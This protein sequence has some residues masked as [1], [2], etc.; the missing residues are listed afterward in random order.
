MPIWIGLLKSSVAL[1]S[2]IG[3]KNKQVQVTD[4]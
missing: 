2:A 4:P 3:L 1:V